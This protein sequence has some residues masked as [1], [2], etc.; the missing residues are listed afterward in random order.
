MLID[1]SIPRTRLC[2]LHSLSVPSVPLLFF[3]GLFCSGTFLVR[4]KTTVKH[5][6]HNNR[7]FLYPICKLKYIRYRLR[8]QMPLA[9]FGVQNVE[10]RVTVGCIMASNCATYSISQQRLLSSWEPYSTVSSGTT[11]KSLIYTMRRKTLSGGRKKRRQRPRNRMLGI[12]HI[13]IV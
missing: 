5:T 4:E 12:S 13:I 7:Q 2:P 9:S 1:V 6:G 3:L 11:S 8:F 10:A